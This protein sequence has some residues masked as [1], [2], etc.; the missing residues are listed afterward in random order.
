MADLGWMILTA[1]THL[2]VVGVVLA[3]LIVWRARRGGY[4]ILTPG[5]GWAL[6]VA[7][8]IYV[9]ATGV[10]ALPRLGFFAELSWN[11]QN[12]LLLALLI[13]LVVSL[14][15]GIS[16]R[17][18]G[19]RMPRRG[20]WVPVLAITAVMLGVNRIG[21]PPEFELETTLF[22]AVV[23]GLDEELLFRGLLLLVL[24]R[25]LTAKRSLW[26]G[27]AGWEVP[28]SCLL[29]ALGHG[30]RLGPGWSVEIGV[31]GFLF[32]A[33]I[34]VVLVWLRI[35]WASLWPALLAHNGINSALILPP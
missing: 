17:E 22:Q 18:L 23:P 2:A 8:G 1:L 26:R 11:W 31:A 6:A 27:E 16:W 3:P 25:A 29:F 13:V 34:G 12:K 10:L 20:W 32:A 14:W 19:V 7:A 9:A 24:H 35:R 15:P 28:I 33:V 21:D 4:P 5:G 30:L